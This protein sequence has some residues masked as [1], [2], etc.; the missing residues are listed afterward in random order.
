MH[1]IISLAGFFGRCEQVDSKIH[2]E[3]QVNWNSQ[4]NLEEEQQCW[5]TRT[6][7][8]HFILLRICYPSLLKASVM[9]QCGIDGRG[10]HRSVGQNREPRDRTHTNTVRWV[11]AK[12]QRLFNEER[13]GFSRKSTW[14]IARVYAKNKP[15]NTYLTPYTKTTQNKSHS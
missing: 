1:P 4:N 5:R 12:M 13:T 7:W 14:P 6:T 8:F 2:M 10:T 15:W 9:R 11:L 3:K